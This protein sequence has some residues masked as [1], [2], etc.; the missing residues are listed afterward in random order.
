MPNNKMLIDSISQHLTIAQNGQQAYFS[1]T[2]PEYAYSQ[3]QLHKNTTKH[4][5]FNIICGESAGTFR[6]KT[7]F[8]GLTYM[9]A[10]F[11]SYGL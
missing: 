9:P 1:T 2:Y 6:F 10:E 8:Y 3:L 7:G 5:K 4:Y 11:Q